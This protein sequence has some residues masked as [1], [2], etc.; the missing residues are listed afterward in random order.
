MD[1]AD[2]N[3]VCAVFL[4]EILKV[5]KMLEVVC[6]NLAAVNNLV[7]LNIVREF[8]DVKSNV[9]F[10]K[11]FLDYGKNFGVRCG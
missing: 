3:N 10:G 6:V 8:L 7:R 1:C 11:D 5:R 4:V 2:R 9:L